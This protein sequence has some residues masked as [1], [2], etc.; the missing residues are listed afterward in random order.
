MAQK[1]G[2]KVANNMTGDLAQERRDQGAPVPIPYSN[3]VGGHTANGVNGHS[4]GLNGKVNGTNG[5]K[6]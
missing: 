2:L 4:N 6:A 3:G 1:S 5:V